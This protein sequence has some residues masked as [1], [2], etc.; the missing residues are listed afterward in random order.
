MKQLL[1]ENLNRIY[2]FGDVFA[3]FL[4]AVLALICR[5]GFDYGQIKLD[6][7]L[8]VFTW[9]SVAIIFLMYSYKL[10]KK[11]FKSYL[12]QIP[13]IAKSIFYS[14][15]LFF[16]FTFFDRSTEYSRL[17]VFY[18]VFFSFIFLIGIRR[19]L[20]GYI[21]NLYSRG[22]GVK[23][24]LAIGLDNKIF[25]IIG[26]LKQ[27]KEVGY[28]VIGILNETLDCRSS[29]DLP[30]D[31]VGNI[32]D[33][34]NIIPSLNVETILI[35]SRDK[36]RVREIIGYC[37][38][39]GYEILLV[40]DVLDLMTSPVQVNTFTSI[41]LIGFKET[42]L[43]GDQGKIKRLFDIAVSGSALLCLLPL[44][45]LTAILIKCDSP[46]PV[47]FGHKRV[48]LNGKTIKVW[49]F[50]TM[51]SNAEEVLQSLFANNPDLEAEFKK[52]FKLKDDPRVTTLGNFLRKSSLDELPQL[53][54]VLLGEMSLV[55][56]RPITAAELEKYKP[57]SYYVL[58]V[59]PG[60]TGMWQ[61]SGRSNTSYEERV[62]MDV[63]YINNWTLWLDIFL[64][65]KTIPAVLARKG[66]Y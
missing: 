54:N 17:A 21:L 46:G 47:F 66:A 62:K 26:Y 7:Y 34:E 50:R 44:F 42:P 23:K 45:I 15:L 29:K 53:F 20:F 24:V 37:E 38:E 10:Y 30:A 8:S 32:D 51:V 14:I 11:E 19:I 43:R 5:F 36:K 58:R 56:P 16:L 41:P 13:V 63:Y 1:K 48:G 25:D 27:H 49:K 12:P 57:Y 3:L 22:I 18:Y 52:E 31:L 40:P 61:A 59:P 60:I 9:I 35:S 33:F 65:L 55:G 39:R 4:S 64:L 2:F 6:R 28:K